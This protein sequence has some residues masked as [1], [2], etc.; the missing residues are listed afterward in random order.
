MNCSLIKLAAAAALLTAFCVSLDAQ[1][2][3]RLP[4]DLPVSFAGTY[5]ELRS[6]HFHQGFDFRV[7]GKVGDPAYA[8]KDGYISRISVSPVGFGNAVYVS[9]PDGTTSIYGHLDHFTAPIARLVR[10]EQY[11]KES[12][13]VTLT[14]S[15]ADFPVKQGD[16][17]GYVGST[18]SSAAPHLHLELHDKD[19]VPIN[20]IK[21][22]YYQVDDDL[23]PEIRRVNF[24]S[25]SDSTGIPETAYLTGF[26]PSELAGKVPTVLLP[27]KSY[28][29]IDATDRQPGTPGRLAV[30]TYQVRLDTA[31]VFRFDIGE[32]PTVNGRSIKSARECSYN[33]YGGPDMIK[34]WLE[35]G[36]ALASHIRTSD[37]GIVVLRDTSAHKLSVMVSDQYG[38]SRTVSFNVRRRAG[39]GPQSPERQASAALKRTPM[40]WSVPNV[41][42]DDGL[43]LSIPA[44]GLYRSFWFAAEAD[45]T[46]ENPQENIWSPVWTIGEKSVPLSTSAKLS[47]EA[48]KVPERLRGHAI[49]VER[50]RKGNVSAI[51][52]SWSG[53]GVSAKVGSFGTYYVTVDSIAPV[54]SFT[55]KEKAKIATGNRTFVVVTDDF[56]GISDYRVEIDGKW[57]LSFGG[58]RLT[59]VLDP[60]RWTKGRMHEMKV[61]AYDN[62][63]NKATAKGHFFW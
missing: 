51:G 39:K 31:L 4:L 40:I 11:A 9:H 47:I 46:A 52:G 1:Q 15:A 2:K 53:K 57:A 29:G 33:L 28:V 6:N 12:F 58:K 35:P 18:G 21:R 50:G 55:F 41:Y 19:N 62:A 63:G 10:K 60:D 5:G 7:G 17:I 49:V 32:I 30:E 24:Y 34:S 20:Y 42:Q 22:G 43:T 16:V 14:F 23:Q 48:D 61:T 54:I 8:I 37:S 25:F 26:G 36:N 45:R 56:S 13:S 38:N 3:P 44:A 59:V 27:E